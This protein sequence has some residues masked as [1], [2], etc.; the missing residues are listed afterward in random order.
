MGSIVGAIGATVFVLTNRDALPDP[1][2]V[3]ALVAW[4]AVLALYLRMVL[5]ASTEQLPPAG[6]PAPRALLVYGASVVGMI[7]LIQLGRWVLSQQGREELEPAVIVICVGL[8][9][10]PFAAAFRAP[11]FHTLGWVM[12]ALGVL[13]LVI[14][15][16][17]TGTAAAA[18][19]VIT[20]VVMLVLI[21]L[22]TRDRL[23]PT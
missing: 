11:V 7:A 5:F 18:A 15:W 3:I 1:W 12:T 8:H 9:L 4:G 17:T 19:A 6:E 21:A 10:L 22:G 13:G 20:G 23:Q 2:P 16:L 14:G